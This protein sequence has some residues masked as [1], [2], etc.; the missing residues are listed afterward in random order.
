[1]FDGSTRIAVLRRVEVGSPREPLVRS[2]TWAAESEDRVL[3]GY[4]PHLK[5]AAAVTWTEYRKAVEATSRT[6]GRT[7]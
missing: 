6:G 5:M 1:M 3:I 2:V 7:G 4:F